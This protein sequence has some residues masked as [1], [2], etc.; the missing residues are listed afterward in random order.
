MQ[1]GKKV[2]NIHSMT[3][4]S[5]HQSQ[6]SKG[7]FIWEIRSLNHRYCDL[8]VHIPSAFRDMESKVR[9]LIATK[10]KRGRIDASLQF[11]PNGSQDTDI[12]LNESLVNALHKTFGELENKFESMGSVSVDSILNFPG[13]M[14]HQL[15]DAT[16]LHP[17]ALDA[18]GI[19]MNKL[20][21][22]RK[23]E[24]DKQKLFLEARLEEIG[25]DLKNLRS[26]ESQWI[27]NYRKNL[28][29]KIENLTT[30]V[31]SVRFE[32][33]VALMAE[34][35]DIAEELHRLESHIDDVKRII[36]AGGVVGRKLDFILQ[37]LHREAN[38]IGSKAVL[39]EVSKIIVNL[40]VVIE[41]IREQVQNI[42]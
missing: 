21:D 10:V 7:L 18:L 1:V 34:K 39:R 42:E 23:S 13:V 9:E 16:M 37:E 32:Q 25:K 40:K 14:E 17:M 20:I 35:V 2:S 11:I 38:T 5:R 3:A 28:L 36:L 12:L 27:E 30:S 24:G 26:F 33:E 15:A 29:K 31:D 22:G 8:I 19:A 6:D 41:Q 4:F